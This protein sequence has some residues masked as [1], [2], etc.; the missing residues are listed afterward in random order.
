MKELKLGTLLKQDNREATA[1]FG[2]SV[3]NPLMQALPNSSPPGVGHLSW[4]A[5]LSMAFVRA[6]EDETANGILKLAVIV[7]RYH[8]FDF[9]LRCPAE[10]FC[11]PFSHVYRFSSNLSE[12]AIHFF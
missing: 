1:V 6:S 9:C 11:T 5:I 2:H 7:Q 3:S 12:N 10:V 8:P 4:D